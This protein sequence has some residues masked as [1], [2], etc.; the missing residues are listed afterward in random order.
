MQSKPVAATAFFGHLGIEW[1]L[2]A[3]T[4]DE[5]AALRE[6]VALHKRFRPL[7]HAGLV[8]RGDHGDP[9]ALVYGVVG[10]D[11]SE[12]LFA[13]AQVATSASTVPL[14][15]RLPGLDPAARYRVERVPLP[16]SA[17]GPQKVEPAWY[18]APSFVASGAALGGLGL[19]LA[20]HNPES[21]TLLHVTAEPSN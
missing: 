19:A 6:I 12:A 16:G 3:A 14:L 13:Y 20:V 15:V 2:S 11:G 5:R 8:V 18:D 4:D 9:A 10:A 1:D 21:A 17:R 7:L